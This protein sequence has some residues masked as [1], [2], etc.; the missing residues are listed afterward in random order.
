MQEDAKCAAMAAQALKPAEPAESDFIASPTWVGSKRGMIFMKG[1]LG[2]QGYYKDEYP[3]AVA[4]PTHTGNSLDEPL[5][6]KE[7]RSKLGTV[8]HLCL[9]HT[10]ESFGRTFDG[11]GQT[12]PSFVSSVC[13]TQCQE[14]LFL[15]LFGSVQSLLLSH[16][17]PD[18]GAVTFSLLP[19][20]W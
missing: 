13:A 5:H 18:E 12:S 4:E 3:S 9:L 8:A 6:H 1:E 19:P 2:R 11:S 16:G 15:V 10:E 20:D 17:H 7:F 14:L